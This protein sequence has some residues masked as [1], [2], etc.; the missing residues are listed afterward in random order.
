MKAYK[1]ITALTLAVMNA[2]SRRSSVNISEE[3]CSHSRASNATPDQDKLSLIVNNCRIPD[4][5]STS[6]VRL[7]RN[8]ICLLPNL[9]S[10]RSVRP[11]WRNRGAPSP[12][13]QSGSQPRDL[14]TPETNWFVRNDEDMRSLR[15]LPK[16]D[17]RTSKTKSRQNLYLWTGLS[18]EL[19]ISSHDYSLA[20]GGWHQ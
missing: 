5:I 11:F 3:R 19:T 12:A 6:P 1:V 15:Q 13:R 20:R 10:C 7:P 9:L 18:V 4:L 16:D 14:E 2:T 8:L 17:L